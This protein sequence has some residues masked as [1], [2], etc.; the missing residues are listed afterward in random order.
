MQGHSRTLLCHSHTPFF[1]H[2]NESGNLLSPLPSEEGEGLPCV[3][4]EINRY[5]KNYFVFVIDLIEKSVIAYSI[6]PGI[7]II[8]YEFFYVFA[9]IGILF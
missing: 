2:S 9:K 7:R 4:E 5:H 8:V 3:V 1:C 6:A